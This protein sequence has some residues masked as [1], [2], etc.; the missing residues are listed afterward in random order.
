MTS[1][2]TLLALVAPA[3][4]VASGVTARLVRSARAQDLV[5][6]VGAV[7]TAGAAISCAV[8]AVFFIIPTG[9]PWISLDA[10]AGPFLAVTAFVGLG[11]ALVSPSYLKVSH[12]SFFKPA[13]ARGWYYLSLHVFW[14][15]LLAIP[16]MGN[17]GI[18]WVV[19]EATTGVSALLVAFNGRRSALE[20]GWKYL[21]LTTI[22]L[23]VALLGVIVLYGAAPAGGGGLRTLSWA[24]LAAAAVIMPHDTAIAGLLLVL[25]GLATKVGWAPV[26]NWLPDAH[27]EAPP[28]VSA[29]LSAA[30]LPS[31]MVVAWR[32]QVAVAPAAGAQAGLGVFV[33]FGLVSLA[34]AVP[35]LWRPLAWKR[36]LAYSSLEH[37]G[38][39]ALGIG[40]GHP[41]ALAGV[42]LHVAGHAVAKSL[43]FWAAIPLFQV[44]PSA[45]SSPIRG[46]VR[47]D[48]GL[49]AT[50]SLS[51]ASLSGLPPSPLFFSEVLILMGGFMSGHTLSAAAAA[52][53]LSLGFL[54]L[55]QSLVEG[56]LARGRSTRSGAV[57]GAREVKWIGMV[58]AVVL[59]LL[60]LAAP[61]L[62][63]SVVVHSLAGVLP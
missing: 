62:P 44:R 29:L 21:V 15:V 40:F 20:A 12:G 43:G 3:L 49:A 22:G 58:S 26:H 10:M 46:L 6:I 41:L 48:P 34:V 31:V 52:L 23:T 9:N 5:N 35:F 14:G 16:V 33:G 57:R 60:A 37:M 47:A 1:D 53:L 8:A 50:M 54:G 61:W 36:L 17:L 63:D 30:L 28:P 42:L 45:Q 7:A 32:T 59:A 19:I 4:A 11:S 39:L 13:T 27:S 24:G 2:A 51:L 38:V 18:A 55:A 56:L 25:A